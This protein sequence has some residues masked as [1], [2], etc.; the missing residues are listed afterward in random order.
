MSTIPFLDRLGEEMRR[1][2]R[3]ARGI[4]RVRHSSRAGILLAG[5]TAIAALLLVWS[6]SMGLEHTPRE[7]AA[8][9]SEDPAV[10][11]DVDV[12]AVSFESIKAEIDR[13]Q[14]D[15]PVLEAGDVGVPYARDVVDALGD[16][17]GVLYVPTYIP[18]GY[19]LYGKLTLGGG[20]NRAPRVQTR[21]L[22][23]GNLCL[24]VMEL[25]QDFTLH[26]IE[27][28]AGGKLE[29][30]DVD[31]FRLYAR[32]GQS[33]YFV[34]F[35]ERDG[36]W[37]DVVGKNPKDMTELAAAEVARVAMSLL[38]FQASVSGDVQ[39]VAPTVPV[40]GARPDGGR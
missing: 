9:P 5:I 31:G 36:F 35:F 26:S 7:Q 16:C 15:G 40:F 37:F 19:S 33:D 23:H 34:Y 13:M 29:R 14:A 38:A 18:E 25:A 8:S 10:E 6:L 20:S 30:V 3:N 4:G 12:L 21:V 24:F 22:N 11:S 2:T 32:R 27:E 1:A 28:L 39:A 17:F